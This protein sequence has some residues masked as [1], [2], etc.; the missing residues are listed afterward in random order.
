MAYEELCMYCFE[1]REGHA[2]CPHCGRDSRVTVPQ[3]QMLPGTLIYHDRFLI[4]RALGQDATGIVYAA[5]DTRKE[6]RL[7]IREYM[8]RDCAERLPDGSVVPIAGM[9]DKFD[10]GMEKLRASV[11]DVEDPRQRHFYFEEYGTAYIAQRKNAQAAPQPQSVEEE[12][13]GLKQIGLIVGI[14]AAV[15]LVAV[16]VII[17]LVNGAL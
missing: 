3:V 1:D 12:G 15:V 8:P 5:F 11:E 13:S 9:E 16:I 10:R 6:N 4:G 14:A 7:R 17:V 2:I